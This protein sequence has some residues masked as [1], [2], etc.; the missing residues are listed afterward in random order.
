MKSTLANLLAAAM[1]LPALASAASPGHVKHVLLISV[2]GMHA[3]DL[4]RFIDHHPQS[5]LAGLARHGIRY[6][7]A[8]T[9]VPAD[10]FPGLLALATGGTP[11]VTGVYYDDT[12]DRS[13]SPPGSDCRRTGSAVVYDEA[14][15]APDAKAGRPAIDA[16][17]LPRDPKGCTPVY[18]HGYL[19]VNTV[20]EVV[21]AA[22][23]HTA[24]IDKHPAYEVLNGPSGKGVDD[25]FTP[26]IGADAEASGK[27]KDDR[28]TASIERTEHYDEHK[29]D[30][31]LAE[32]DG[33][34]HDGRT[35]AP[36]P[37]LF[38]FN[39]QAVNVAQKVAGYED[40][41]GDPTPG[42]ASALDHC[43]EL[44]GRIVAELKK[45]RLI[46]STLVIV[47][48]KHGNGPIDPQALRHIDKR[49]LADAIEAVAPGALAHIT[50]DQGALVWLRA[51]DRAAA[52]AAALE[53]SAG[54]LG[55]AQVLYGPALARRFHAP[56]GDPR[57]PDLVVIPLPGVIYAKH[58]DKKKAE[59]GG[60]AS[61]DT[62]VPLLVSNPE[63]AHPGE[64]IG[65]PVSTTQVAPT[66]LAALGIDPKKLQ[67]VDRLHTP[68]L[69][70]LAW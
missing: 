70:G 14:I 28:I 40:A 15:D 13:L 10:S 11:A 58:G 30:A 51:P 42:L 65:T 2:D 36:V 59:H 6:A 3:V 21:R 46:A 57:T 44:I 7:G 9:V 34:R 54:R 56:G 53:R 67:A 61:D 25:L 55:I 22:G 39:I 1:L 16:S 66:I 62:N 29:A 18:P 45:K 37:T 48:A 49:E 8:E 63:L 5:V 31:L 47:T 23:G 35:P 4:A 20:F 52:V 33:F 69:P 43:D 60:Y 64:L 32:I 41:H 26:E 24:W 12:Y 68:V 17:R 38:G 50:T 19:R 27:A